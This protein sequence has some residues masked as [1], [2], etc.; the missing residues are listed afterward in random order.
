MKDLWLIKGEKE[1]ASVLINTG[2]NVRIKNV[3]PNLKYKMYASI[4]YFWKDDLSLNWN[5]HL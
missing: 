2:K 3:F 1:Q 5:T 4:N